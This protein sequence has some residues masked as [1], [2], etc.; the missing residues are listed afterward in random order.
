MAPPKPRKPKPEHAK[1]PSQAEQRRML[2][3]QEEYEDLATRQVEMGAKAG[4]GFAKIGA[5]EAIK[6]V[7]SGR[8]ADVARLAQHWPQDLAKKYI[9]ELEALLKKRIKDPKLAAE[10]AGAVANG[11]LTKEILQKLTPA[12]QDKVKKL[13]SDRWDSIRTAFWRRVYNDKAL[14][15]ELKAMNIKFKPSLRPG[16][17]PYFVLGD[18]QIKLSID[19]IARKVENPLQAFSSDNLRVLT[20]RDNSVLKEGLVRDIQA[21]LSMG[22]DEY[23]AL[24]NQSPKLPN[25][26]AKDL[27]DTID[28][29]PTD[30][31][32]WRGTFNP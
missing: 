31:D 30:D 29:L 4:G 5:H 9:G 32:L 10:V 1:P 26:L 17:A 12:L 21:D 7:F 24:P 8:I 25:Q 14:R 6:Q 18:K 3:R 20:S 19:H 16:S 15:N 2:K 27:G 28:K 22:L 13:V 23:A 11:K